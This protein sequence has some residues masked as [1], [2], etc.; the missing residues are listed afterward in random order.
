MSVLSKIV[1]I[2]KGLAKSMATYAGSWQSPSSPSTDTNDSKPVKL[3]P[4]CENETKLHNADSRILEL[5]NQAESSPYDEGFIHGQDLNNSSEED[6][7]PIATKT[8]SVLDSPETVYSEL[9]VISSGTD[10]IHQSYSSPAE[11][12]GGQSDASIPFD[13]VYEQGDHAIHDR[14]PSSENSRD[15]V[16]TVPSLKMSRK[17][18]NE[19]RKISGRRSR[20]GQSGIRSPQVRRCPQPELLCHK[21]RLGGTWD[22]ELS[23]DEEYTIKSVYLDDRKLEI[24]KNKCRIPSLSGQLFI[25]FSDGRKQNISLHE[26]N[27]LIFKFRANWVGDG[28]KVTAITNGCFIVIAPREW[29]RT[30]HIPVAP[31]ACG[32]ADFVAHFFSRT[33]QSQQEYIGGFHEHDDLHV[34]AGIKLSGPHV[35]DDSDEGKLF[36]QRVPALI[37]TGDIEWARV[38][39]EAKSGWKGQNFKPAEQSLSEILN[40]REGRFFL[41]IYDSTGRLVDSIEFRFLKRLKEILINGEPYT[42]HTILLPELNGHT[43]TEVRFVSTE[44]SQPMELKVS[45]DTHSTVNVDTLMVGHTPEANSILCTL[46]SLPNEVCIQLNLPRIWWKIVSEDSTL[47][48]WSDKPFKMTRHEFQDYAQNGSEIRLMQKQLQSI[49]AG[50]DDELSLTYRISQRDCP[51]AIPMRDFIDHILIDQRIY[52]DV[53]FKVEIAGTA[54]P[55]I[56]ISADPLPKIKCFNASSSRIAQGKEVTLSWITINTNHVQVKIAPDIGHVDSEGSCVVRPIT[57]TSYT[58]SLF[59][60]ESY[61]VDQAVTVHID[62]PSTHTKHLQPH[63]MC[64]DRSGWK[65]AKGFSFGEIQ[66]A[67]LNLKD[68]QRQSIRLDKR[69]R[70]V[71]QRNVQILKNIV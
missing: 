63:A 59:V 54:L 20:V 7:L 34:E 64:H 6:L 21:N 14:L 49:T 36:V 33:S 44:R 28:R 19:P 50:F 69:R 23:V 15:D 70:T 53:Q 65:N 30:G 39:E 8:G 46:G 60:P 13:S 3:S 2:L 47:C 51:V 43:Q 18:K 67:G 25:E 37:T 48:N 71:H 40:G 32:D 61:N 27:P 42:Q 31:E 11:A 1:T 45:D 56:V 38:G 17:Q 55:L 16:N 24:E 10:E 35:F 9:S 4:P 29:N 22:I 12:D 5:D 68:T 62:S 57:T 66:C 41:R 52:A 58:L 26:N